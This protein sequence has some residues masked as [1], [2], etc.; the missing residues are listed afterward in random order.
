M[1]DI[2]DV[3]VVGGGH[4]G[5][6]A[7]LAA[8]RLGAS[9][10]LV[11]MTA[12]DIA[13]MPCNPSVGGIAKS[14][15]VFELDALGGEI[16][17]NADLTGIQFRVLNTSKG[18]AVRA[19][20]AQCDKHAYSR[21]MLRV[22]RS[23]QRLRLIQGCV[24]GL[25]VK[26]GRITGLVLSD[27]TELSCKRLVMTPGTYL[28]GRIHVGKECRSGGRDDAGS[29]DEL[30]KSLRDLGFTMNRLKTGT[31]PRLLRSSV[32]FANLE[33]QSGIQPA[34]LFSWKGR[35][36]AGLFHVEHPKDI[37]TPD[38][39]T[40]EK[41]ARLFHV[42]Q[43]SSELCPWAP[44]SD[45]IPC[46]LTHT[47]PVTHEL[48]SANLKASSLYG[49]HITGTGVRYCPSV[50]D[51]IVKFPGKASH[52]VFLEPEGRNT[53]LVYPNGISNSLPRDIQ[54]K[55]VRSI[56]GLESAEVVKW[57]Y[58]IEYDFAD[59]RDLTRALESKLV[60]GLYL[61]GQI[62]GTTGYEEAAAQGFIAGT[63]AALGALGRQPLVLERSEAYIGVLI[64]DLVT[65]GTDEPYRMFTSRAEHRLL[66]R[67]DNARYRM[68][69]HA[70]RL[71]IAGL[72]SIE[73]TERFR[74]LADDESRRL[75]S[76]RVGGDSLATLLR[77]RG[78]RYRTLPGADQSLPDEVVEQ[79]E[80]E[81]RYGGYIEREQ[82]QIE[83]ARKHTER[84]IPAD[85]DYWQIT[86]LRHEAREKL[87]RIRPKTLAQAARIP[88]ISPADIG[89]LSVMMRKPLPRHRDHGA[90]RE[91][92]LPRMDTAGTDKMTVL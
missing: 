43:F 21:R 30:G 22:I 36:A 63:N 62:N 68:L 40:T 34:P 18:P 13:C 69:D 14:H 65:R 19:N 51:K 80:V 53:D 49:G 16:G 79:V 48:I 78:C 26:N 91:D 81:A 10:A 35:Q 32:N 86:A 83:Q 58:A 70:R 61:A 27:S 84:A 67:Q 90:Y 42:E 44:G 60:E 41:L 54:L 59:P 2:L 38:T 92:G 24:T 8:A 12:T 9:T 31:P 25:T 23:Q 74:R 52:H 57:A 1:S 76:V 4:A 29:A 71:G 73:Q 46:H 37:E 72:D 87:S 47:T 56:P 33:S 85:L 75:E 64:D 11:T 15:L 45:Q 3:V 39:E 88:G 89:I 77:R 20:R 28:N 82:R 50:E 66:L 6:E 55:V 17:V 5:C 7:A